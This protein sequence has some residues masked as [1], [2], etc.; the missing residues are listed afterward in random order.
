MRK[1]ELKEIGLDIGLAFSKHFYK[2]DYL[3]YGYWPDDLLVEPANVF[4]AQE[5]YANYLLENI[6]K[7]VKSILDVGCGSGK[8]AE[9]LIKKGFLVDCVSPSS[10]LNKHVKN[11][12]GKNVEI[13]E[14]A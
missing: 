1:V 7:G 12:L 9:K 11:L 3:H 4:Q 10:N 8:F 2:T 6:P 14:Y 13:F 5:N